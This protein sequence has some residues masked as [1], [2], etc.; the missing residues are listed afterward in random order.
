MREEPISP[1]VCGD[2]IAKMRDDH[3]LCWACRVL[4]RSAHGVVVHV[5]STCGRH[6]SGINIRW[7]MYDHGWETSTPDL[8]SYLLNKTRCPYVCLQFREGIGWVWEAV[9]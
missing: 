5:C 2:I 3:F 6:V 4:R 7:G 9:L 8:V 1:A